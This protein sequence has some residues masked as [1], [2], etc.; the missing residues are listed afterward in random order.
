MTMDRIVRLRQSTSE[1]V[2]KLRTCSEMPLR[3]SVASKPS[4][5]RTRTAFNNQ[6]QSENRLLYVARD[7]R[8]GGR[9]ETVWRTKV[10]TSAP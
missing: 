7:V 6:V 3:S 8:K 5:I 9:I 10:C 2:L 4:V 1:K